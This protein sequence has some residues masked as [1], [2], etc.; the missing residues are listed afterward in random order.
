MEN[1]LKWFYKTVTVIKV[2]V[3]R[4]LEEDCS[5]PFWQL[6]RNEH[7]KMII[8]QVAQRQYVVSDTRCPAL[9]DCEWEWEEAGQRPQRGQSPVLTCCS[10]W[11]HIHCQFSVSEL[12]FPLGLSVYFYVCPK[13][14]ESMK[15][16]LCFQRHH[17][18]PTCEDEMLLSQ[19]REFL[20]DIDT[21]LYDFVPCA[22]PYP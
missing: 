8:Q 17:H 21:K 1:E 22:Q 4:Q 7:I 20:E 18:Y 6:I 10:C 14:R 16:V 11:M 3:L 19:C 15:Q 12:Q 9:H 2:T 5:F 13:G